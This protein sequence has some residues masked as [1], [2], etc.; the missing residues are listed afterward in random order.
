MRLCVIGLGLIGGSIALAA[1]DRLGAELAAVDF[2]EVLATEAAARLTPTRIPVGDAG[3]LA[4]AVGRSDLTLVA[5]PVS[6]IERLLPALL[7]TGAVITDCGSTKRGVVRV[8][9]A[10]QASARFVAGHPM[11]G[12]PEGGLARADAELFC[13]RHWILCPEGSSGTAVER[14]RSLVTGVGAIPVEM[15]ALEHD[16]AVA[17]T[18]HV[19]QI[20]ASALAVLAERRTARTGAG[21]GFH[22]ATRVAGGSESMWRDIFKANADEIA[23][24]LGDLVQELEEVAAGLGKT[25]PDLRPAL[26]LLAKARVIRQS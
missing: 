26:D 20:F 25:E 21:P 18:S 14:V 22:S 15:T 2:P 3:A 6:T 7:A 17:L 16:R 24:A 9:R 12:A 1:R 5:T 11:A 10:S 23:A 19:P 4:D 8:A 13:Q